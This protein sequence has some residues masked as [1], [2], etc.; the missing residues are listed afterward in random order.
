MNIEKKYGYRKELRHR[1]QIE[2]VGNWTQ[3]RNQRQQENRY[4]K[5]SRDRELRYRKK[6]KVRK[7]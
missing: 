1:K 5:E 7:C 2:I 4:R 3:K 6:V